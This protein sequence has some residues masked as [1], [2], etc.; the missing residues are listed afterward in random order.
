[1]R[2][3]QL[4][5]PHLQGADVGAWQ[6]FLTTRK[7]YAGAIDGDFGE[8]TRDSTV[9]Y[10]NLAQLSADGV[11]GASTVE[12][13]RQDGFAPPDEAPHFDTCAWV[14][15]SDA[16]RKV[17]AQVADE[18]YR[19]TQGRLQVTSGTRT[20]ESQAAAMYDKL[21]RG[22]DLRKLYLNAA[23][24]AEIVQAYNATRGSRTRAVGAMTQVIKQQV[25]RGVY[26]SRHLRGG[27]V[28]VAS[29]GMTPAQQKAFRS[30]VAAAKVELIDEED[31]FHLQF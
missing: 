1:M 9:A 29:A 31:H 2:I 19:Q 22:D 26:I 10:Q 21:V 18:Y 12:R 20:P 8:A 27:G 6:R 11:V 25:A 13:A 15:M 24:L 28:D 23:A 3:L 16:A 14:V 5:Q 4:A 7:L 30:A 17:M